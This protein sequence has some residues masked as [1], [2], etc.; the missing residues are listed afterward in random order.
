MSS[1]SVEVRPTVD[2]VGTCTTEVVA[3]ESV[4]AKESEPALPPEKRLKVED[5]RPELV[6]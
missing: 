1:S 3:S 4:A 2:T 5:K 6:S